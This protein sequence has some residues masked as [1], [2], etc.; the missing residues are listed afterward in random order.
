M[1][2]LIRGGHTDEQ[3]ELVKSVV[4]K[5]TVDADTS[6]WIN[7]DGDMITKEDNYSANILPKPFNLLR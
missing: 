4:N 5:R 6:K 3:Q 7:F 2:Y 1:V